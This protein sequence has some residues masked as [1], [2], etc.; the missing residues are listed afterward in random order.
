MKGYSNVL[1]RRFEDESLDFI[2]IDARHD[3]C[4]VLEDLELY[5]PKLSCGGIYAGHDYMTA[6]EH[7]LLT[8]ERWDL[9]PTEGKKH[10]GA[11]KAAVDSFAQTR[12]IQ[13]LVTHREPAYNTWYFRKTC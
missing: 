9:C 2:Y 4:S 5:W 7:E 6:D 11:V 3:F 12:G 1:F 10:S 8:S 13:V